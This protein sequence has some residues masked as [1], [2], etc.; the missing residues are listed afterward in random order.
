MANA[1]EGKP[2]CDGYSSEMASTERVGPAAEGVVE[3]EVDG[4]VALFEPGSGQV[5]VLNT[6]AGDVWRLSDGELTFDQLVTTLARS[7]SVEPDAISDDVAA[8]IGQLR[9]DGLLPPPGG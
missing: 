5:F 6:T 4:G 2:C 1:T 9:H 8:A 3:T 7:Y